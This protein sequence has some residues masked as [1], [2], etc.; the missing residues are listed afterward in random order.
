MRSSFLKPKIKIP[1]FS[2]RPFWLAIL[3][4]ICAAASKAAAS[5]A[6]WPQFRGPNGSGVDSQANPPPNIS[7]TNG[8]LWKIEVPWSPSSPCIW[9]DRIFLTT[10]ADGEL[11][12][13]CYDRADGHMRWSAGI[14]TDKLETFH[15]SEGSPA[16]AT[17]ATDGRR[18]VSYF[19]SF[20]LIG[21]DFDG[22]EL[23]RHPLS[24]ALS[25]GGFGS[26]TSPVIAGD[27]VLLNR[28]QE[29]NSSLLA[30]S[31]ATGKTVWEASRADAKGSFG[32]PIIWKNNGSD[33]VV[34]PGSVRLKGY[35]LKTGKEQW[36]VQGVTAFA[37]TTPVIGNGLLFFAGWAPGKSDAP[38]PPWDKFLEQHDKNKDGV[39]TFDEFDLS[40]RDFARAMDMDHDGQITK[41]DW[42][43]VLARNASGENIL[44]AIKP[45]GKG[46]ISET[47]VAWK[48]SRGLP[49]VASP[50]FYD[51][52]LYLI[53]D[54]GLMS[55][56]E[57]AS[58]K[59][60][61]TQERI[62][63]AGSYYASPVAAAGRIY[64]I[65]E[66]GKLSILKAGGEKP[67]ILY[68]ANFGERV[69]A[70]PALTGDRFYLRT[71]TK[72]YAFGDGKKL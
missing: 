42:D 68:Q 49:Y 71:Q 4:L 56:F 8:V 62:G 67:E 40:D 24:V 50:L 44:V 16:A 3:L 51:G 55:S 43:L 17:P 57:A 37:C 31:V 6:A 13:R 25:G 21:Y 1:I 63:A 23:W 70:T 38:F 30:A 39:I 54:G 59:P 28:D 11:Q 36:M 64:V 2:V 48:F 9:N 5:E 27:L 69:F 14:K 45:G 12:T 60:I 29:E 10:F 41:A 18:V 66:P 33:E 65:S 52:R 34:M 58:G 7:P 15:A 32:T 46:N 22:K 20:G 61:Y 35:D 72:L 19:G 47:H 53:R 26:G